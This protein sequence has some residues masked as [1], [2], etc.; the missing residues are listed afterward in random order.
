MKTKYKEISFQATETMLCVEE[1]ISS[2]AKIILTTSIGV[3][4]V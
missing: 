2:M 3:D 4:E 1:K